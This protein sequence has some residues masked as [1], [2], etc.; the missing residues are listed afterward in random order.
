[1]SEQQMSI[2]A[3]QA[4]VKESLLS[5]LKPAQRE[6]VDRLRT[7]LRGQPLQD[8]L[9]RLTPNNYGTITEEDMII[10]VSKLNANVMLSDLKE[11]IR[12]IKGASDNGQI[13]VQETVQLLQA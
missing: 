9:S 1:M 11:A 13:N 8:V 4:R 12:A 7:A 2:G 5:K 6:T 3:L 10:G